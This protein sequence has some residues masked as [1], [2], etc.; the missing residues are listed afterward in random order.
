MAKELTYEQV[1]ILL[2]NSLDTKEDAR[3]YANEL[4][5]IVLKLKAKLQEERERSKKLKEDLEKQIDLLAA[6]I[7][8]SERNMVE[9][10]KKLNKLIDLA[11]KGSSSDVEEKPYSLLEVD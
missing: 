11:Q 1:K 4:E 6:E 2:R 8:E 3:Q 5:D 7:K 9:I 10:N